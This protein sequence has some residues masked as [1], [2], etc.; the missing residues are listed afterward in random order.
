MSVN[1]LTLASALSSGSTSGTL[2][3]VPSGYRPH[4]AIRAPFG[5]SGN[6]VGYVNVTTGGV[7]TLRNSGSGSIATSASLSF[8]L[9]FVIA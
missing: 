1:G 4:A 5:S 6:H 3:T 7:I 8:Q 2:A 9:V